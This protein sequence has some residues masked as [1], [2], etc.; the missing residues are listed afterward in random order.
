M[1]GASSRYAGLF[2]NKH[3]PDQVTTYEVARELLG[4]QMG[5]A[6]A[7]ADATTDPEQKARWQAQAAAVVRRRKAL[8]VGTPEAEQIVADAKAA[9]AAGLARG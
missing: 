3:T 2:I 9:R 7:A 6:F 4:R 8:R 5:E 1:A